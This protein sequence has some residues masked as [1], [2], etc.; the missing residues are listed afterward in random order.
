MTVENG[1][2]RILRPLEPLRDI[3]DVCERPGLI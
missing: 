1:P 2:P 3:D